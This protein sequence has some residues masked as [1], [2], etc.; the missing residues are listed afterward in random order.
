MIYLVYLTLVIVLFLAAVFTSIFGPRSWIRISGILGFIL[1]FL[2]SL[3]LPDDSGKFA[4]GLFFG[5]FFCISFILV[6]YRKKIESR[7]II[8][9]GINA[10]KKILR[11]RSGK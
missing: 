7:P 8:I 2:L 11:D 10:V 3:S 9:L 6:G 5:A 1:G 4:F